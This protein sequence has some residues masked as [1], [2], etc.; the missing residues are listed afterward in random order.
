MNFKGQMTAYPFREVS[1]PVV[2]I[3]QPG[4]HIVRW[5]ESVMPSGVYVCQLRA[6]NSLRSTRLTL[7]RR[8]VGP[9]VCARGALCVQIDERRM[10]NREVGMYKHKEGVRYR[11]TALSGCLEAITES[12][13]ISS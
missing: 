2:G 8:E 12:A 10:A 13:S 11:L 3:Q 6:G 5:D 1:T 9:D 7:M 4:A